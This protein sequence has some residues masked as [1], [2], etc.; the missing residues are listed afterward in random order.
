MEVKCKNRDS[1]PCLFIVI[2]NSAA[3][4][5][6]GLKFGSLDFI[7]RG[8]ISDESL[9]KQTLF[10]QTGVAEVEISILLHDHNCITFKSFKRVLC[11]QLHWIIVSWCH[12]I[13]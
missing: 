5:Y 12:T 11:V 9:I 2:H 7:L 6:S 3:Q 8:H 4:M 10:S 1:F 13:V